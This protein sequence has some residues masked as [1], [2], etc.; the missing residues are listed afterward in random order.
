M[1]LAIDEDGALEIFTS[2]ED[3]ERGLEAIDVQ[4]SAVEFCDGRGQ[5]YS[6]IYIRPPRESRLGPIGIVDIGAFRLRAEGEIDPSLPQRF[7]ARARH[8]EHTS[9]PSITTLEEL[10][11]E[12]HKKA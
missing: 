7:I 8:I 10:Q 3:A 4:Q 12:L 5:R 2:V 11:N 9:I 1:I 6:P